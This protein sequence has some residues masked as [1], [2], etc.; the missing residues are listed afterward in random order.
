MTRHFDAE[1]F[2]RLRDEFVRVCIGPLEFVAQVNT[3]LE[4]NRRWLHDE[5]GLPEPNKYATTSVENTKL[6]LN[7]ITRLQGELILQAKKAKDY[8]FED[9][10]PEPGTH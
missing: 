9:D 7:E 1:A 4:K 10:E 3:E 2:R 5:L 6:L 8:D